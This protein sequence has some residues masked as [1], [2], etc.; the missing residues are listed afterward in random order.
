[1]ATESIAVHETD[2]A[3][4]ARRLLEASQCALLVVDFQEKLLPAILNKE[5]LVRNA[6][7]LIRAANILQVPVLVTTQ[8]SRGL[9]ST[10]PE[11]AELLS[12]PGFDKTL[13]G[14]F[15]D[16]RFCSA[17]K[18]LPGQ[19]NTLLVCGVEAHI[20][21]LQTVMGALEKGYLVHVAADAAGSRT[22][23]NWKVGMDRM[24]DAGAVISSTEII[25]YELLRA[26]N[27]AAFKEMLPYLK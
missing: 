21:V 9:G 23:S 6:Q 26:S 15:S 25:I 7:L 8:Y 3:G 16:D 13:F 18:N 5:R 4:I 10:V 24:R 12:G 1:M 14:C 27:T 17:V 19:R 2:H 20:C 22:E 11:L